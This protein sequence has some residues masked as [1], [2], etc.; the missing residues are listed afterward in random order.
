MSSLPITILL[1]PLAIFLVLYLLFSVF[2][3]FHLIH[4]GVRSN[5]FFITILIYIVGTVFLLG[6]SYIALKDFDWQRTI[7]T[8]GVSGVFQEIDPIQTQQQNQ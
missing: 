3:I 8:S 2:N 1:I 6:A 4:Y 7:D 5:G